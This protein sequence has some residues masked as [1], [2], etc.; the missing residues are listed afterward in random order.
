M[1]PP[2]APSPSSSPSAPSPSPSPIRVVSWTISYLVV[3]SL[4]SAR[5]GSASLVCVACG[6]LPYPLTPHLLGPKALSC[7]ILA[8]V[9]TV[10][11]GCSVL[12]WFCHAAYCYTICSSAAY[13]CAVCQH[14]A[15]HCTGACSHG[16]LLV[17]CTVPLTYA[18]RPSHVTL[19]RHT[20][21]N[22]QQHQRA[23][24]SIILHVWMYRAIHTCTVGTAG[25]AGKLVSQVRHSLTHWSDRSVQLGKLASH[26]TYYAFQYVRSGLTHMGRMLLHKKQTFSTTIQTNTMAKV[27]QVHTVQNIHSG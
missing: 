7:R 20:P 24:S 26:V 6:V 21:S 10:L 13:H 14:V 25:Q 2:S 15:C 11:A 5:K 3:H 19:V 22:L 17:W 27:V 9:A 4:S 8:T 18:L 23:G 16:A 12:G 1:F